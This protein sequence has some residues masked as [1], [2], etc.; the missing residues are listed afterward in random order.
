MDNLYSKELLHYY[1]N[2]QYKGGIDAMKFKSNDTNFSCGDSITLGFNIEGQKL[3]ACRFEGD[4]CIVAMASSEILCEN[5][6]G[7]DITELKKLTDE[8][9]LNLLGFE[10]TISRTRCALTSFQALKKGLEEH[11]N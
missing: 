2:P 8:D 9:F 1:Q 7:K 11:G 4:G 10:L 6:I 3:T 5:L